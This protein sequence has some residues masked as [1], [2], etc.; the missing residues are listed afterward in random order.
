MKKTSIWYLGNSPDMVEILANTNF[1]YVKAIACEGKKRTQALSDAAV[2]YQIPFFSVSGKAELA[3]LLAEQGACI[4]VM[5]D[6]GIIIPESTIQQMQIFN[7][8]PGSLRTNRGSS[9]LNWAVL[10]GEKTTEMSLHKISAEID[11][12]EL[13][14]ASVCPVAYDDTPGSLRKKLEQRIPGMLS[15]L[16]EYLEGKR[17]STVITEGIYRR[18]ITESDYEIHPDEDT[19]LQ[20]NAKIRSQ[21]EYK[22][23]I[24]EWNGEKKYIKCWGDFD[25][26]FSN[27]RPDSECKKV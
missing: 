11:K 15:E 17:Q 26:V 1:L 5:Y 21:A 3:A 27:D 12:G 4:A 10:L 18:R 14:S 9:P 24:L 23:A 22:G 13:I 6:F 19:L 25:E 8:H 7:F 16:K 2:R 20:V